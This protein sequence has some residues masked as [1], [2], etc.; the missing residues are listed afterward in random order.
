MR[1]LIQ[2]VDEFMHITARDVL[3]G[4]DMDQPRKAVQPPFATLFSRVLSPPVG[5]PETMPIPEETHQHNAVLRLQ[6]RACPFPQLG[7]TQFSI[8]LPRVPTVL[9]FPSARAAT[10]PPTLP[11][12]LMAI[13]SHLNTSEP[14][15]LEPEPSADVAVIGA[16]T[17]R[18]S[19][20]NASQ[21]VR[22]E[23]TGSVYLDTITTS[24]SRVVISGPDVRCPSH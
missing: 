22:D 21:V 7:P 10:Q 15:E 11:R 13:A 14:P 8:C 20:L 12:G 18:V 24:I 17:P 16:N 23:L 3:E 5:K 19:Q 9:T 1:E 6:G 2:A 4:L